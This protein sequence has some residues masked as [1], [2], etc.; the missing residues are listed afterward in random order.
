MMGRG[1]RLEQGLDF[2][3]EAGGRWGPDAGDGLWLA[4]IAWLMWSSFKTR[5]SSYC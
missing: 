1:E 5:T 3:L 2:D 4:G